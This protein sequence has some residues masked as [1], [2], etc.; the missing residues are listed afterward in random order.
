MVTGWGS[1]KPSGSKYP[2]ELRQARVPV[3][4]NEVCNE[5]SAYEGDITN[6]MI[7][8]GELDG[9]KGVCSGDSGGPLLAKDE[10]GEFRLLAGVVS[11]GTIPCAFK[12]HPAVFTRITSFRDW[13]LNKTEN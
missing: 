7:C 8:A 2:V 1:I 9:G 12:N 4:A 3:V 11:F 6:R 13:I 10:N 5:A